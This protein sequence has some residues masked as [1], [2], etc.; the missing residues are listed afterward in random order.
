MVAPR[1]ASRARIRQV[2]AELKTDAALVGVRS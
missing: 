1:E 2:L